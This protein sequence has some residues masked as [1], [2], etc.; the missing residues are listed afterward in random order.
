MLSSYVK[1]LSGSTLLFTF[2]N[3][4]KL[5]LNHVVVKLTNPIDVLRRAFSPSSHHYMIP[6]SKFPFCSKQLG[7]HLRVRSGGHE[8]EGRLSYASEI[9]TPFIVASATTGEVYRRISEKSK[10]HGFPAG[11]FTSLGIG[12]HITGGAYGSMM[13][14]Y[15]LAADSVVDARI[16][17]VTGTILDRA[18]M[19]EDL[20][21]AITGAC[22]AVPA[23]SLDKFIKCASLHS[24]TPI[25]ISEAFFNPKNSSFTSVLQNSAQNLRFVEPSSPKPE[26]IF[27]PFHDSH[28]QAAVICSKQLGIHLRIRSGGHD[29]EGLSYVS[30]I[31]TPFIVVDLGKLRTIEVNIEVLCCVVGD[32]HTSI[33]LLYFIYVCNLFDEMRMRRKLICSVFSDFSKLTE[34]NAWVQAG[35]TTGEVYYKIAKKSKVHGYPAGIFTSLGFGGHIT[36]GAYGSLLRK[37]GLGADN[38]MDARI[39]DA[40]GKILDRS[41]MGEDLFWAIRGGGGASFGIILWWKIKLVHVPETLTAFTVNRTLEQ[42]ATKLLYKWQQVVDKLDEDLFLRVIINPTNVRGNR[43]VST[44][45]NSLFLGNSDRLLQVTQESFPELGLRRKDCVEMSWIESVVYMAGFPSGSPLEAMLQRKST[46]LTFYKAKSDFVR[47]PIPE[48]G[49][50]SLWNKL[51]EV[52]ADNPIIFFTPFGGMMSKISESEIPFPHRKGTIFMVQ[53]VTAWN[54]GEKGTVKHLDWIMKLYKYMAPYVSKSPREAYVNYRDLDVGMNKK[55]NTSFKEA[56]VWVTSIS[57]ITS[58]DW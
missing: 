32:N 55:R 36:G 46:F 3:L 38:V 1:K 14:K 58:T 43:T 4:L 42:G 26:F 24:H 57:R 34:S 56:S 9:E 48:N 27:T 12:G 15:G 28:V 39:V 25:P 11:I 22:W 53:Y 45:Y 44:S 31:E 30:I 20:F 54:D 51:L 49:L 18:A 8:Y 2:T 35:A 16:I 13:R 19:G 40:N 41:A 23:P 5:S 50:S 52:E 6:M 7:L 29:Y 17:D 37:Y 47:D 10:I 21:L 33:K